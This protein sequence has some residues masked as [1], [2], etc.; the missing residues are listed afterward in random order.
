MQTVLS[1]RSSAV[2]AYLSHSDHR[3]SPEV[4]A[5]LVT[6]KRGRKEA[7][8]LSL[9]KPITIGRNPT[10]C[11]YVVADRSV[12]GVHCKIY[13]VRSPNGG[14]IVS[15]RDLSKNGIILNDHRIKRTSAILMDGD[16]IR[17]PDSLTFTCLHIWKEPAHKATVFDPT[18]PP[19]L[20]QK[21]S[22][23]RIGNYTLTSQC[24]GTGSFATVHLAMDTAHH[25]QV[26]CKSI[27]TKKEH[28]LDQVSKEVTILLGLNHVR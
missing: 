3:H 9:N 14:V 5:K 28:E 20:A 21:V 2:P 8:L 18:P 11:S 19:H 25:C 22:L 26:A 23:K 7:I 15:C 24:L 13:A 10:L 6:F 12:S 4:C 1:S 17:I 16:S 27:R